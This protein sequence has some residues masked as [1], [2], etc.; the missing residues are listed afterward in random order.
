MF[1]LGVIGS[2]V[3]VCLLTAVGA[4]LV[5]RNP[6]T[7]WESHEDRPVLGPGDY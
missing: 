7:D 6:G 2:V 5:R 1:W 4:A 3:M